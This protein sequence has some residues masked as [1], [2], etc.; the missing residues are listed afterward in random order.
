MPY[1]QSNR[2]AKRRYPRARGGFG[3]M[4]YGNRYLYGMRAPNPRPGQQRGS[5]NSRENK[6]L[7]GGNASS[8]CREEG[9]CFHLDQIDRGT[10]L[11]NAL[12]QKHMV[13]GVHIR[14]RWAL[15]NAQVSDRPGYYLVWDSQPN[16]ALAA[17]GDIL[18]L[19]TGGIDCS[20]AFPN[21]DNN[22]RFTLLAKREHNAAN[23]NVSDDSYNPSM[24][25]FVDEY[26]RFRKPL[27][28]TK[29]LGDASGQIS[30]RVTGALIMLTFGR[31]TSVNSNPLNF[32]FRVYFQD[33]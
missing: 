19:T 1:K 28:A 27:V 25:W 17:P 23:A 30:N 32:Q 11:G 20:T 24:Y 14:G 31:N 9:T 33:V 12:G 29:T 5:I 7:T 2:Y 8:L 10:G 15:P 26:F 13:T 6:A 3:A 16:E 21:Q 4:L 22:A 18:D